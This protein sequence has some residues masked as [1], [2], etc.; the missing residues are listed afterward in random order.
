MWKKNQNGFLVWINKFIKIRSA[1]IIKKEAKLFNTD[2]DY[3]LLVTY[4]PQ[5]VSTQKFWFLPNKA[6]FKT[7]NYKAE[8]ICFH[9]KLLMVCN[10]LTWQKSDQIWN[11]ILQIP[12]QLTD[13][14]CQKSIITSTVNIIHNYLLQLNCW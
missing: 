6:S 13:V 14:T 9:L 1:Q 3:F 7:T 10:D 8:I 11:D 4:D 2:S 5:Y 12:I